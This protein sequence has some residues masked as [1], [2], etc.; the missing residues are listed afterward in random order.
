[1]SA[2]RHSRARPITARSNVIVMQ[3]DYASTRLMQLDRRGE[4]T[5]T[6]SFD[7]RSE[8]CNQALPGTFQK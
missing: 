5:T 6:E 4:C 7:T 1:M 8:V 2:K 3:T